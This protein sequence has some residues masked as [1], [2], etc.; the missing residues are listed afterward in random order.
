MLGRVNSFR[1]KKGENLHRLRDEVYQVAKRD[2]S[3]KQAVNHRDAHGSRRTTEIVPQP[4]A[5]VK[6]D[7]L[8]TRVVKTTKQPP[9]AGSTPEPGKSW[10]V[11]THARK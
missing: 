3:Y 4:P 6:L 7:L 1:A 10:T 9:L 2:P 5:S 8:F 11:E